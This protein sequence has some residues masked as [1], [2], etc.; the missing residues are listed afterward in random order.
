MTTRIL[1]IRLGSMGDVIL[2]SP[3]ILNLKRRYPRSHLVYL[4]RDQFV[5]LVQAFDGVDEIVSMP[6]GAGLADYTC[7]LLKLDSQGFDLIVD[8]HGNPRSWLARKLISAGQQLVYPKRRLD[9]FQLTRKSKRLPETWP[10]T[11]DLYNQTASSAGFP[12][13][14]RRPL[15]KVSATPVAD[16]PFNNGSDS[17]PIVFIAPGARHANKQWPMES[18]VEVARELCQNHD[19]RVLW[20]VVAADAGVSGLESELPADRFAELVQWPVPRLASAIT[21]C[22]MAITNDSGLAHLSSAVGT[23]VLSVFGP[24]HPALGFAPRGLRDKVIEVDEACRPCSLHGDKPCFRDR[25]YCFDRIRPEDVV[26]AAKGFLERPSGGQALFVDR[27][28]TLIVEKNYASDPD[29]IEFEPGTVE[30]LRLAKQHGLKLVMI[31][32]QSGVARGYFGLEAVERMNHRLLQMLATEGVEVDGLYF[33]PHHPLGTVPEFSHVC[34]CRKPAVGM[35]EEAALQLG[36]DLRRSF[37][38]GD[39]IDDHWLGRAMGARSILVRTGH[40]RAHEELLREAGINAD[41]AVRENLLQAVKVLIEA[42]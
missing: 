22:D 17:R 26:H 33:C 39:K 27:D 7:L 21:R 34:D 15:L 30:A 24:T 5:P 32:N 35:A 23:P 38:V 18:F 11:I 41:E 20:A 2:T 6:G 13:I 25:R 40:G 9:R 37:V 31:S 3:T 28:G 12:A 14:C 42:I 36:L 8:L 4:T 29:Q 19:A 1:V 16:M 10:H